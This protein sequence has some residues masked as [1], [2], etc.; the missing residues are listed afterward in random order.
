LEKISPQ[1]YQFVYLKATEG[2]D[3]QDDKFQQYW[4]E[5]RERGLRVGAYHSFVYVAMVT[6]KHK[7]LSKQCQIKAMPLPPVMD[8][9]YD[10]SC[11]NTYTKEQLIKH[12]KNMH[13][14]LQKHYGK[15]PI[16]YTSK[17]FYNMV[18]TGE[19]KDTPIW[20]R[21]YKD[22]PDLKDQRAWT[23]WQQSN[24]G[25]IQGIEKMSI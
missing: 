24:Q 13:D 5:A 22:K 15:Q 23:F 18:L 7:I 6:F 17:I 8:L 21:E 4:L 11:I 20:I 14:Q 3:Y 10:S 9:E 19:F 16:F 2:G 12:I 1:H 25:K